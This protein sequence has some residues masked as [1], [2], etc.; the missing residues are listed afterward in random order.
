MTRR[1]TCDLHR[2][3]VTDPALTAA[4]TAQ[5]EA[6]ER[7]AL[8]QRVEDFIVSYVVVPSS[9]RLVIALWAIATWLAEGFDAFPYLCLQSPVPRCG[10]TR[11]LEILELLT[12]KPWRGTTPSEA[13][14]FRFLESVPTLLLDE[15]ESLRSRTRSERGEAILEI[16]N[17]GYRQ[18][19]T[20]IRCNG[21]SHRIKEFNVYGPKA[22]CAINGLPPTLTDRSIIVRMQ[23]RKPDE[24]IRRFR[25]ARA[26]AESQLIRAEIER[27]VKVFAKQVLAAYAELP[28]LEFLSDRDAELFSPL[29]AVCSA[30]APARLKALETDA[31]VLCNSKASDGKEESLALVLLA[32]L[33]R[34]WPEGE[35]HWA[36]AD[37]LA[38]I[39][40]QDE[41]PWATD[42]Q[43]T[44]RRLAKM[45]KPFEVAPRD[46]RT[47]VG[48]KKGYFQG[49]V[50]A[51]LA[52]YVPPE[53]ATRATDRINTERE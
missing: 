42:V 28:E 25:F 33:G 6:D 37:L 12:R 15:T 40:A 39:R 43:L 30:V 11:L 38:K 10:K 13:A 16:L 34:L 19:A 8:L 4:V 27:Q 21:Q 41:S 53:S 29:F 9:T 23:R 22:F 24:T 14:L 36:T 52:R 44:P 3:L 32:D 50:F 35:E 48:T 51:A 49:Q 5:R 31:R 46:L 2:E 45:L 1:D 17:C 18:G 20:V 26:K 7:A 47:P